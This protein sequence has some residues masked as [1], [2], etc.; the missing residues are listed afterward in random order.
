MVV[1]AIH[2][3]RA[4]MH[5]KIRPADTNCPEPNRSPLVRSVAPRTPYTLSARGAEIQHSSHT[6]EKRKNFTVGA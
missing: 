6:L 4:T 2:H 3:Q 5:V 1:S